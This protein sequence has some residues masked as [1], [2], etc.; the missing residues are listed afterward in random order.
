MLK[1]I[2]KMIK[3]IEPFMRKLDLDLAGFVN[4]VWLMFV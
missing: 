1:V 2:E 3:W 4:E